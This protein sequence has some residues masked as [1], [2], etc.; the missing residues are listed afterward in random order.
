MEFLL[1]VI[2]DLWITYG[3]PIKRDP[4]IIFIWLKEGKNCQMLTHVNFLFIVEVN[5]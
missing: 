3:F 5:L 4:S 1:I 2:V